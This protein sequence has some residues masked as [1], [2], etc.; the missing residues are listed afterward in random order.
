MP[1]LAA[2]A[3]A[4]SALA[5]A[6][7]VTL[8]PESD[9]PMN[10]R[11]VRN[12]WMTLEKHMRSNLSPKKKGRKFYNTVKRAQLAA[13][14]E[15]DL[16]VIIARVVA[17]DPT[18]DT[19][20]LSSNPQMIG[21]S[22][23]QKLR[24]LEKLAHGSCLTMVKLNSVTLDNACGPALVKLLQSKHPLQAVSFEGNN[25]SEGAIVDMAKAIRGHKHLRELSLA[26]QRSALSTTAQKAMVDSMEHVPSLVHLSLGTVRDAGMRWTMQKLSSAHTEQ[27]RKDRAA[28]AS[29]A[30]DEGGGP[31]PVKH[32]RS[33]SFERPSTRSRSGSA[34]SV[35]GRGGTT[36]GRSSAAGSEGD[37][38]LQPPSHE[39]LT[40]ITALMDHVIYNAEYDGDWCARRAPHATSHRPIPRP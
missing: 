32:K 6:A 16:R 9:R 20:D 29:A 40:Q 15:N 21:L 38:E 12:H 23:L 22:Q 24:A 36:S 39:T 34:A 2:A 28:A 8:T 14:P 17:N 18:L 3:S 30:K 35:S 25:L 37:T 26:N 11:K 7:K 4:A 27:E 31:P 10:P 5:S 1:A 19:L 33:L 13:L